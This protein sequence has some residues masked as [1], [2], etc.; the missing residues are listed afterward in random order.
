MPTN[1]CVWLFVLVDGVLL[2][3]VGWLI[4][5]E[6]Q[7]CGF[8]VGVSRRSCRGRGAQR[9]RAGNACELG[10]CWLLRSSKTHPR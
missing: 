4:W 10:P 6:G 9:R 1:A 7:R 2:F 3:V 8:C 5:I